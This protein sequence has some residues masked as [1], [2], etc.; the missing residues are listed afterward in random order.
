MTAKGRLSS[1]IAW[2][3]IPVSPAQFPDS[4]LQNRDNSSSRL[5]GCCEVRVGASL[6]HGNALG[7]LAAVVVATTW[8]L[9]CYGDPGVALGAPCISQCSVSSRELVACRLPHQQFSRP[10]RAGRVIALRTQMRPNLVLVTTLCV[11]VAGQLLWEG[12][13]HLLALNSEL[14]NT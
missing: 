1:R 13:L 6:A 5:E 7:E 9:G 11:G 10:G 2:V 14:V 8:R 4:G 12:T 3:R